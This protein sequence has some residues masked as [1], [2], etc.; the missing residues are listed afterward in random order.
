MKA[1]YASRPSSFSF[2]TERTLLDRVKKPMTFEMI[3]LSR[4]QSAGLGTDG[5]AAQDDTARVRQHFRTAHQD[6]FSFCAQ[7]RHR[8]L[9]NAPQAAQYNPQYAMSAGSF[10]MDA[11]RPAVIR[12][13]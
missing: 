7:P 9:R 6:A 1:A 3:L 10:F 2:C 8:P 4:R 11:L 12:S 13:D 5:Q